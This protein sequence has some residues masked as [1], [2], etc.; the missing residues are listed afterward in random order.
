MW[1]GHV[2]KNKTKQLPQGWGVAVMSMPIYM[3][4]AK[5]LTLHMCSHVYA[6]MHAIVHRHHGH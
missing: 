1:Q 2:S 3:L 5:V 4:W 6:D